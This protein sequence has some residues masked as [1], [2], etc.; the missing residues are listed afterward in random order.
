MIIH[1][2][3]NNSRIKFNTVDISKI[4]DYF[5]S[6]HEILYF[7]T[8]DGIFEI[9]NN[10]IYKVYENN[11]REPY[12]LDNKISFNIQYVDD[13]RK[14]LFYIPINYTYIKKK[15]K[16]YKLTPDSLLTLVCVNNTDI[17]FET[18]E[19]EITHS[20]KEDLITFLSLVKLYT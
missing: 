5:Q 17:Y 6:N 19:N 10:K 3:G 2:S 9:A 11:I 16:K 8:N 12:L 1:T 7:N 20:I 4:Q 18:P 15:I 13:V 14:E